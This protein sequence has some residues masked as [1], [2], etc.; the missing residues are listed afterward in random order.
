MKYTFS[1]LIVCVS[2]TTRASAE[3]T[4]YA[5]P[6]N[7]PQRSEW[8]SENIND[9]VRSQN[10][11]LEISNDVPD[12][13]K[14]ILLLKSADGVKLKVSFKIVL[15]ILGVPHK[16][17]EPKGGSGPVAIPMTSWIYNT[18]NSDLKIVVNLQINDEINDALVRSVTVKRL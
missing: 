12:E 16:V 7:E 8:I 18:S 10:R 14:K 11:I 5:V 9:I 6:K 13:A 2:L 15:A 3:W 17:I 4:E 1:V